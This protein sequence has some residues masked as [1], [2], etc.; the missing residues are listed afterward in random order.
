MHTGSVDARYLGIGL[1]LVI[2][3]AVVVYG[4]LADRLDAKRRQAAMEAAPDRSIP[5]LNPEASAPAYVTDKEMLTAGRTKTTLSAE[6]RTSLQQRLAGAPSLHHG[7]AA[8]EFATDAESGLCVLESPWI[9]VVNEP[10]TTIRE[11][12]PFLQKA[13]AVGRR[14]VV[15]APA[16]DQAVLGT[17]RV[18]A[19]SGTLGNAAVVLPNVDQRRALCSLVDANPLSQQDLR[20]GYVPQSSIGSCVT[21]VSSSER[22][23]ILAD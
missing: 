13:S 7:H 6:A 23:W 4:W 2:G 17:L 11:L 1:V 15:V 20:S 19:A 10:V 3:I 9:L 22:L 14:V 8:A 18:N 12:L 16:I 21:W 5:G